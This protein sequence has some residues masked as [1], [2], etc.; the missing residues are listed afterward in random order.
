MDQ[1]RTKVLAFTAVTLLGFVG[2]VAY[3]KFKPDITLYT[4]GGENDQL[5]T[6][7]LSEIALKS[8]NTNLNNNTKNQILSCA[9]FLLISFSLFIFNKN[10][11]SPSFYTLIPTLGAALIILF[12]TKGTLVN[13]LLSQRI[14]VGVGL[15]SY[16]LY[17]WHQPVFA[18]SR[19]YLVNKPSLAL[20]SI[21]IIL[22]LML[23]YLTYKYIEMPF[24]NNKSISQKII[25][26]LSMLFSVIFIIFGIYLN[27]S[28]GMAYRVFDSAI[29]VSDMDKRSYNHR[30]FEFKKDKFTFIEKRKIL[31]IGNSFARD[32]INMTNETF[33]T[34]NVEIV[35][36]DDLS[37]CF[38][39]FKGDLEE[40]LLESADVII[41]AS[42]GFSKN[43]T[44]KDI[45]FVTSQHKKIF[46]IGTKHFGSNLNW[47]IRLDS[48]NR[49]NQYNPLL[50]ATI[51]EE[52]EM[53]QA[54][55]AENF[56][57]LIYPISKNGQIPVTDS[58]G[59]LL[60]TDR[61]HLTKYGAIYFGSHVLS[62]S[63]YADF[64]Q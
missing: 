59:R 35:Y 54:I 29:K 21:L 39:P 49:P 53:S 44:T 61:A 27:K 55:P 6:L 40:N 2:A 38:F 47:L 50:Q 34:T 16:S 46:Y 48:K 12:A 37:E 52:Q 28:Y 15:I 3:W 18:F 9:G 4:P 25:I 56:I 41:L 45:F 22:A 62:Q 63:P 31:V 13:R 26:R 42:G 36:R 1:G 7:Q 57:S 30:V 5:Q 14:I 32:F 33:D 8:E 51:K 60:S 24:R 58:N 19:I 23:A 64:F 10:Y 17:L 43:C 20:N 11:P